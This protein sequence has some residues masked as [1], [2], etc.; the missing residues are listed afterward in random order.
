MNQSELIEV[1][2]HQRRF[3]DAASEI[4]AFARCWR[5]NP[6]GREPIVQ[7]LS[8]LFASVDGTTLNSKQVLS[9]SDLRAI[10]IRVAPRERNNLG[11]ELALF[12][13]G[14]AD[15][16]RRRPFLP[17]MERRRAWF[18]RVLAGE[19]IE[20]IASTDAYQIST[21]RE[22]VRRPLVFRTMMFERFGVLIATDLLLRA[23]PGASNA[24]SPRTRKRNLSLARTEGT[25]D[26]RTEHYLERPIRILDLG[27]QGF[28]LNTKDVFAALGLGSPPDG[29][30]FGQSCMD[31]ASAVRLATTHD[32]SLAE[33][34]VER[35]HHAPLATQVHPNCDA[36]WS[37]W[38]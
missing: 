29:G 35:F 8:A 26:V 31:L 30:E 21:I 34:L 24:V 22:E 19:A 16:G 15:R 9:T 36:D 28:L 20:K 37:D 33:W 38:R 6:V 14:L 5:R 2:V 18:K 10:G 3:E 12:C 1:A 17:A 23:F 4:A 25:M 32:N 7:T 27:T 13:I 11:R